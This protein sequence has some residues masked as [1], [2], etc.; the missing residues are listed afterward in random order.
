MTDLLTANEIAELAK[1]NIADWH[2]N[3]EKRSENTKIVSGDINKIRK[4]GE[5][6]QNLKQVVSDLITINTEMWHK[7]D[8][9]R[10]ENDSIVLKAIKEFNPLNQH[11]NDLIE[12]ID[13]IFFDKVN[14]T[15]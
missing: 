2:K 3:F 13:E 11:R 12:E 14:K 10:S 1:K 7:Q 6:R 4:L 8:Q 5:H 15:L 9:F